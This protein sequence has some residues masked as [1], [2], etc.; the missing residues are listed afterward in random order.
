PISC[1][2]APPHPV[3]P[4]E[5]PGTP[6]LLPLFNAASACSM[7]MVSAGRPTATNVLRGRDGARLSGA[8]SRPVVI[9]LVPL[10]EADLV[11]GRSRAFHRPG[12]GRDRP[13]HTMLGSPSAIR[14]RPGLPVGS[15][16]DLPSVTL[17]R[18]R[19]P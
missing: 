2:S 6:V 15:H 3:P 9:D 13:G 17:F 10:E 12:T 19:F 18:P 4:Y 14:V 7:I 8:T 11:D 1:D 5:E 16:P